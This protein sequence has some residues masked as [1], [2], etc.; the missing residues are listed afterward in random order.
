MNPLTSPARTLLSAMA[1]A[2]LLPAED[3][4]AQSLG[5]LEPGA[6]VRLLADVVAPEP[7][8]GILVALDGD[9]MALR[10]DGRDEVAR[11]PRESLGK[12]EVSRG[13]RSRGRG[14]RMG[15][16][17]GFAIG[18]IA[19]LATP[20]DADCWDM[21]GAGVAVLGAAGAGLGATIGLAIPPGER[22]ESVPIT[23]LGVLPGRH[24]QVR[25]SVSLAF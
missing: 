20:C 5:R 9:T 12:L 23:S 13:R 18:A 16:L 3:G 1:I 6:R 24:G 14:A 8:V 11:V 17:V 22:W 10:L 4:H 2:A 15:A 25:M 21:R 19:V 7:V